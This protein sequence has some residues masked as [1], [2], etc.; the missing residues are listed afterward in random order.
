MSPAQKRLRI[1]ALYYAEASRQLLL[2]LNE[3]ERSRE[4]A[5]HIRCAYQAGSDGNILLANEFQ[6]A[7]NGK[8]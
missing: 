4:V 5:D 3:D 8:K 2:A 6:A 7:L 1:A